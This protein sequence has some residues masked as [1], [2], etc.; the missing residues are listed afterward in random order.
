MK[1]RHYLDR[2]PLYTSDQPLP[3]EALDFYLVTLLQCYITG[4]HTLTYVNLSM[5]VKQL[6]QNWSFFPIRQRV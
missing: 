6:R 2:F 3:S 4:C 1:L 5:N